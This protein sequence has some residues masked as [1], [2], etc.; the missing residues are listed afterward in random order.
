MGQPTPTFKTRSATLGS[1]DQARLDEGGLW[2]LAFALAQPP[3][4]KETGARE[5]LPKALGQ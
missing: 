1:G 5:L 2:P 4:A 3:P